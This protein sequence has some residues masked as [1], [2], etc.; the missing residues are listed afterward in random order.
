MINEDFEYYFD[1]HGYPEQVAPVPAND[2]AAL[3]TGMPPQYRELLAEYGEFS[4]RSG[5]LK[6]IRSDRLQEVLDLVFHGDPQFGDR[7]SR[8]YAF[9][10]FGTVYFWH[11]SH[12]FGYVDLVRG[13]V[14]CSDVVDPA[15]LISGDLRF[16]AFDVPFAMSNDSLDI[17]GDDGKLLFKR[18]RKRIGAP[19][20]LECYGFVPALA[21]GGEALPK[22]IKRFSAPEH[23]AILAEATQF[24]LMRILDDGQLEEV[25]TVGS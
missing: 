21:F 10:V 1:K 16:G 8:P 18:V 12:N 20:L 3:S 2:I 22:A 17:L 24:T 4:L 19:D 25:R 9:T 11:L 5:L 23:F 6:F 15:G 14:F 7:D 13:Q